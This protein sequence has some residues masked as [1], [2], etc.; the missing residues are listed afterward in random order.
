MPSHVDGWWIS[1]KI[2]NVKKKKPKR[3]GSEKVWS[4]WTE[5]KTDER[6]SL[7][8]M[9]LVDHSDVWFFQ[10]QRKDFNQMWMLY[11]FKKFNK[12]VP[13]PI[14]VDKPDWKL[15]FTLLVVNHTAVIPYVIFPGETIRLIQE[16]R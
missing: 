16:K 9:F 6:W 14:H 4:S 11:K 5:N 2:K 1:L 3:F 15:K 12:N 13:Y 7:I 10:T 8:I